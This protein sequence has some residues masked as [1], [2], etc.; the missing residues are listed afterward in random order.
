[1][2]NEIISN[3]AIEIEFGHINS[4]SVDEYGSSSTTFQTFVVQLPDSTVEIKHG[5]ARTKIKCPY[6]SDMID[7][8]YDVQRVNLLEANDSN[9]EILIS[10]YKRKILPKSFLIWF[11]IQLFFWPIFFMFLQETVIN[12][13]NI[14]IGISVSIFILI[15]II[16]YLT[17]ISN[18]KSINKKNMNILI[19]Q[20]IYKKIQHKITNHIPFD[21]IAS[22]NIYNKGNNRHKIVNKREGSRLSMDYW[23]NNIISTGPELGTLITFVRDQNYNIIKRNILQ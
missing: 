22:V 1:M 8:M 21:F 4:V 6:C 19:K 15:T 11:I 3:E 17:T 5:M 13:L 12:Y 10:F 23:G 16:T 2:P 20:S 9:K 14:T 7:L 18:I